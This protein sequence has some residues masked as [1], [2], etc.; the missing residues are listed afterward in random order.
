MNN[1][2]SRPTWDEY[3]MGIVDQVAKRCT[4][5]RTPKGAVIVKD[6][7]IISTGYIGSISGTPHCDDVGHLMLDGHCIRTVHA[8]ANAVAQAAKN[9][10]ALNNTTCYTT[11]LP[12]F[13]CLK[14]LVNSGVTRIVYKED[15]F[16]QPGDPSNTSHSEMSR[17]TLE[18]A[19]MLRKQ[20]KVKLEKLT[21]GGQNAK[22]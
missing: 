14:L 3:F 13:N 17:I 4:C 9:G 8:E 21:T 15:Y 7:R 16:S 11:T 2:I 20:N 12:C 18:M 5:S 1:T 22:D 6:N 10:A 19:A